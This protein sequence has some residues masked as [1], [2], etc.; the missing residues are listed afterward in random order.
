MQKEGPAIFRPIEEDVIAKINCDPLCLSSPFWIN[1]NRKQE[2]QIVLTNK[3]LALCE[4]G[5]FNNIFHYY[6]ELDFD[7]KF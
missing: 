3:Y 2:V 1:G 6:V 7:L 4:K 5:F